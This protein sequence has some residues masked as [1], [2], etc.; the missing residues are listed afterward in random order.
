[1]YCI[2][3]KFVILRCMYVIMFI[4]LLDVILFVCKDVK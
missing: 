4:F 2:V 3:E 1:M